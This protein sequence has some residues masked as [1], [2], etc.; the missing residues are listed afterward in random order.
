MSS[1]ENVDFFFFNLSIVHL[2]TV[3]LPDLGGYV[4]E[5]WWGYSMVVLA[6]GRLVGCCPAIWWMLPANEGVSRPWAFSPAH[7]LASIFGWADSY[8]AASGEAGAEMRSCSRGRRTVIRPTKCFKIFSF[9]GLN[10]YTFFKSFAKGHGPLP[11]LA[12]SLG[13]GRWWL[14]LHHT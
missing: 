3:R 6:L 11:S 13:R 9:V 7:G 12:L 4:Y 1:D 5:C 2:R 14:C 8:T 10:S